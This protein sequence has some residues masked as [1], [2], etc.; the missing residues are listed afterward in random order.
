MIKNFINKNLKA[1]GSILKICLQI[2]KNILA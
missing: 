1:I 2:N